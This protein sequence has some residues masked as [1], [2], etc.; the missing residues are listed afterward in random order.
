M[1]KQE[2]SWKAGGQ[3]GEGLESLGE[4]FAAALCSLGYDVYGYRQFSSRIKG[5]HTSY[6]LRIANHP[7]ATYDRQQLQSAD[8]D[9]PGHTGS[10]CA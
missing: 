10:G 8:R 1:K 2:L 3:Q 7:V 6:K 4:I 5:G 9:G